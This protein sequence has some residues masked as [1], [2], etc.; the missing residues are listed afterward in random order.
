M[1]ESNE[2]THETIA[3]LPLIRGV[4]FPHTVTAIP[5]G[6]EKSV[7]LVRDLRPGE[8][9]VVGVQVSPDVEDP[10][11]ADLYPIATLARVQQVVR[12]AGGGYRIILQGIERVELRE[13]TELDPYWKVRTQPVTETGADAAEVEELFERLR[14]H[15]EELSEKSGG[16]LAQ[17]LRQ[18]EEP[19]DLADRVASELGLD[20]DKRAEV[21]VELNIVKR[22]ESVLEALDE[23]ATRSEVKATIDREVRKELGKNQREAI[24]REQLKAIKKELGDDSG[25][26]I[27]EELREKLAE[28][29][30]PEEVR[31][32][33]EREFTR[34]ESLNPAQA[35]YGVI[36]NYL[37]W[38]VDLP[39]LDS[40]EE[41][42]DLNQIEQTLDRDHYG[43][44][45]IKKRILEHMAVLK[46]SGNIQGTILALAG[47]PGT[48]KTSLAQSVADAIGRPL[49]RIS[50][51][52]VRDEAEIRGHRRTYVGALPGRFISAMRKAGVNN[53][54][55]VLDEIDKLGNSWMG[56]PE[57]GL[58]EVLDPEQNANFTDHYL[59]MPFDLSNV[60]FI[61][62]AN[63]LSKISGPLRDRLEIIE[64]SGYT[65]DEKINIAKDHLIPQR[66]DEHGLHADNFSITDEALQSIV[67]D[68]TREAGVRQ[69]NRELTKLFRSL[70]LKIAQA[71]KGDD[72]V[73]L[74]VDTDDL[75]TYLGKIRFFNEAAA[76][77]SIP[78]VAT[79]LAWTPV[80]G[81][82]LFI[83]TTS[84]P[85]KGKL[86]TTG[87][88]GDVMEESARAALAYV[89]TNAGE[90][91]IDPDFLDSQ[92]LHIHIPAGAVPKDGPSAGVTI[93]TALTSLLS[94]RRVRPD[95]AMTGEC[96]LRGRVLPVGGIKAKVLAAH[97][98]GIKRVILPER[99]EKDLEDVPQSALDEI[100]IIFASDMS[101]V[102]DNALEK[103]N[104]PDLTVPGDASG[105]ETN[106]PAQA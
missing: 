60:I 5:V 96:S 99:N 8:Q 3:L 98:A 12:M 11:L 14:G 88:L 75:N 52:G 61:C 2:Q 36:R 19:G 63:E 89:R 103:A 39:W 87:Q 66:L 54:V 101:E 64:L 16:T 10:E 70:T 15:V 90:L 56:S 67:L 32:T 22:L 31:K 26:T 71:D 37:E 6:R 29:N 51:G 9:V 86:E 13:M 55:M 24:L 74:D 78:G 84:M 35:E 43:L 30:L 85:G 45:D 105:T 94:G 72:E 69:L 95:T 102:L 44:H 42:Y 100:E 41:S 33:A 65:P 47:P 79:G 104:D 97:R 28:A 83:E 25:N 49:V 92:D 7:E 58:L 91:G 73:N 4:I 57:A 48:G 21:L 82:I 93:F 76:R 1:S 27:V 38:I 53:P 80:G 23:I 62:T 17:L 106:A 59:E 18:H 50:L 77:T 81:D 40:A 20:T 68:Y 46:V 34:M